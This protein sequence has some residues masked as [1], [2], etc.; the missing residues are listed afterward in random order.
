MVAL[1]RFCRQSRMD[2]SQDVYIYAL[3]F[4]RETQLSKSSEGVCHLGVFAPA[5]TA[6]AIFTID[7][8]LRL[9]ARVASVQDVLPGY[10]LPA[11][12]EC[13]TLHERAHIDG[14]EPDQVE[15]TQQPQHGDLDHSAALLSA[16]W[17]RHSSV[18]RGG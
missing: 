14:D 11:V 12:L 7:T 4:F 6:L 10:Q 13:F 1:A 15:Q 18:D 8:M 17:S 2:A 3:P 16:G 5:R 9:R